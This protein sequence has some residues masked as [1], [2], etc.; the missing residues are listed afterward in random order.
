MSCEIVSGGGGGAC[1]LLRFKFIWISALVVALYAGAR[2]ADSHDAIAAADWTRR[3]RGRGG[4]R[5][6]SVALPNFRIRTRSPENFK[7]LTRNAKTKKKLK[8]Y[9]QTHR[10]IFKES[11][12]D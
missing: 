11:Y 7:K 5:G 12:E 1:F 4:A 8:V 10:E 3:A 6:C 2:H 9:A